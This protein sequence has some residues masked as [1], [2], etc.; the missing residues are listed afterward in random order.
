MALI[1]SKNL[2]SSP[3]LIARSQYV[4]F[5]SSS[6]VISEYL[7]YP[8]TSAKISITIAAVSD[9][10]TS[11]SLADFNIPWNFLIPEVNLTRTLL[12]IVAIVRIFKI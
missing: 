3:I 6:E 2:V 4:F 10:L 7:L 5:I 8:N 12:G 11:L 1:S 9:S